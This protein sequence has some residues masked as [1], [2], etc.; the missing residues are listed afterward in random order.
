VK[1]LR[2][3]VFSCALQGMNALFA[4]PATLRRKATMG[5]SGMPLTANFDE[6][7]LT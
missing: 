4:L 7:Q 1:I 5:I 6:A 3:F 2:I